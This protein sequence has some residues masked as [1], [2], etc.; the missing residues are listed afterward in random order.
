ME[1]YYSLFIALSFLFVCENS[2]PVISCD[3]YVDWK[4]LENQMKMLAEAGQKVIT[5]T[6][7]KDP[8]N[9][10]CYDAYENMITWTKNANG[11][12]TYDYAIFDRWVTFMMGL[13]IN[14]MIS[15]YSMIPWNNEIRYFDAAS[16]T[17]IDISAKPGSN[18]F[19]DL[20]TPFLTDFRKHL[21]EKGWLSITNIAMDERS[22]QDMKATL[23]LLKKVA[24]ELGVSLAD[25]HKSYQEYPYLK[26]ICI[27]FRARFEASDLSFRKQNGLISTYYVCCS[28][29]FPNV[30]TFSDPAE[31]AFIAWYATAAGLDGFLHWAYNSWVENPVIDSRFRTWP[32][33]DTYITYPRS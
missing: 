12:W 24:P 3:A 17:F 27:S 16:R 2:R 28:D 6:I 30:F 8:W 18:E 19:I 26:D 23:D 10:Q 5:A 7:N 22:P 33:G 11:S 4:L 31:G 32:A 21:N 14:K 9:N 1:C 20:W 13:G 29:R 15:C 25:N